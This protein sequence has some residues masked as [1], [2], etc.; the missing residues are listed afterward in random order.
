[1]REVLEL[2]D[3]ARLVGGEERVAEPGG[4]LGTVRRIPEARQHPPIT[5]LD[6][7]AFDTQD[8]PQC[9]LQGLRQARLEG[10]HTVSVPGRNRVKL[11]R[12]VTAQRPPRSSV[13]AASQSR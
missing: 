8:L 9:L 2:I 5:C 10:T 3:Q 13:P 4:D 6:E 1:V 11:Q 7:R 12:S